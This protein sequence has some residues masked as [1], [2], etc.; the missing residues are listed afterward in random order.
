MFFLS[1]PILFKPHF[2]LPSSPFRHIH[3]HLSLCCRHIALYALDI[4]N[5]LLGDTHSNTIKPVPSIN[6][7]RRLFE[8]CHNV[9]LVAHPLDSSCHSA[10]MFKK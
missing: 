2:I 1:H 7:P 9:H 6:H 3:D 8:V 4:S 10:A 5:V